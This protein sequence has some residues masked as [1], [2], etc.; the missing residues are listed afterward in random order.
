[1]I[2]SQARNDRSIAVIFGASE[3]PR[4]LQWSRSSFRNTAMAI[5][6]YLIAGLGL[7]REDIL[8]LFDS[9]GEPSQQLNEIEQFLRERN[10]DNSSE[11]P[12]NLIVYYVGHGC[13]SSDKHHCFALRGT[14]P[15]PLGGSALRGGDLAEVIR[16]GAAHLRRFL[17][18]DC[19]F[20]ASLFSEFQGSPGSVFETQIDEE[21]PSSGTALLCAS[22]KDLPALAPEAWQYTMFGGAL[23]EVLHRGD[24]RMGPRMSLREIET[25]CRIVVRRN[26]PNNYT[27]PELHVPRAEEGDIANLG[28]FPNPAWEIQRVVEDEPIKSLTDSTEPLGNEQAQAREKQIEQERL[29][30]IVEARTDNPVIKQSI[31][32]TGKVFGVSV[33]AITLTAIIWATANHF[34]TSNTTNSPPLGNAPKASQSNQPLTQSVLSTHEATKP[35]TSTAALKGASKPAQQ[36]MPLPRDCN[37]PVPDGRYLCHIGFDR[38]I[39]RPVRID[40]EAKKCLDDIALDAQRSPDAH[41]YLLGS[42]DSS[43]S[44]R[45]RKA[46]QRAL[47]ASNYLVREKGLDPDRITLLFGLGSGE[48][49]TTILGSSDVS[50]PSCARILPGQYF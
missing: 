3:F 24:R 16:Q 5:E 50:I 41:L 26:S 6:Q 31:N 42:S 14:R 32:V 40:G 10:P 22:S 27:R 30:E 21:L 23:I 49:V 8:D 17:F 18:I 34:R 39:R 44:M 13:F 7:H 38:D 15:F 35:S 46:A 48:T 1:M 4:H 33:G 9:E 20:A 12:S 29:A 11:P 19:C 36:D 2:P 28:V 47:N 37:V 43:E 25:L 45:V